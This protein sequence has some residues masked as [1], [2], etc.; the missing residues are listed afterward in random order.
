MDP[1]GTTTG[2][3]AIDPI[4]LLQAEA[5]AVEVYQSVNSGPNPLGSIQS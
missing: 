3:T 2:P 1:M 5:Y 4:S